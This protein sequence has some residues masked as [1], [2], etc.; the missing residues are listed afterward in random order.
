MPASHVTTGLLAALMLCCV[1]PMDAR[2]V[3]GKQ[4]C[5]HTIVSYQLLNA[6]IL[7]VPAT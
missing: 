7:Q 2:T 6:P 3:R 1:M 4:Q 5:A